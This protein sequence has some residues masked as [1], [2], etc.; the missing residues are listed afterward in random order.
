MTQCKDQMHTGFYLI[1]LVSCLLVVS[2]CPGIWRMSVDKNADEANK[3]SYD[4][5]AVTAH[6][7]F[8]SLATNLAPGATNGLPQIIVRE[9]ST[10]LVQIVSMNS[11]GDQGNAYSHLPSISHDGQYVAFQSKASNLVSG[12][13]NAQDDIFV[14]NRK[15]GQTELVSVDSSGKQG[16]GGSTWPSISADGRYVA[17]ESSNPLVSGDTNNHGDVYVRD[18]QMAKTQR[19][20][21]NSSGKQANNDSGDP[22]IS[23]DGRY[24]AFYSKSTDLISNDTNGSWDV[25]VHDRQSGKTEL[26]SVNSSGAQGNGWSLFPALS[27]N[28]RYVAFISSATNLVAGDTNGKV[29]VFVYDRQTAKTERVSVNSN[30]GQTNDDSG[31]LN[32]WRCVSISENG[33]F[34]VFESEASNLVSDDTNNREDVFLRDRSAKKTLRLSVS[35]AGVQGNNHSNRP[36]ITPYGRYVVFQSKADNLVTGD[37]NSA[38]DVF[39]APNPLVTK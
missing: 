8:V 6:V 16:A 28:G 20:S 36:S 32:S 37:T 27:G 18:R 17:F 1:V 39:M 14:H 35:K 22:S 19:V 13:T 10:N 24:I 25:F 34:V 7:A 33:D 26:V 30:G 4:P 3:D 15:A 31:D 23:S 11:K 2:G 12:D 21:V 5:V 38:S 29:D 9:N